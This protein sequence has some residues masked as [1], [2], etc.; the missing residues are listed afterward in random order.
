MDIQSVSLGFTENRTTMSP[1]A[2]TLKRTREQVKSD[3]FSA[4]APESQKNQIQPE[5]LL[6]NIKTLTD[7]GLYSVR[8]EMNKETDQLIINLVDSESGEIIRQI[9]P[10]EMLGMHKMLAELSG[11]LVEALS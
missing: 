4:Q 9:P 8:F 10:E 11:N 1:A 5:E 2:E 3:I 7:N 6:Q